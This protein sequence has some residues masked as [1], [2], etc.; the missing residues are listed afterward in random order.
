MVYSHSQ[1]S[2]GELGVGPE[3]EN[4]KNI[5]RRIVSIWFGDRATGATPQLNIEGFSQCLSAAHPAGPLSGLGEYAKRY[6]FGSGDGLLIYLAI[7]PGKYIP[8]FSESLQKPGLERWSGKW[9]SKRSL[10]RR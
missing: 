1:P 10:P 3:E 5:F 4:D 6:E 7:Y 9:E 8:F 2:C